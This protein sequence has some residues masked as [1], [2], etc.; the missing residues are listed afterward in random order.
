MA[1]FGSAQLA[2]A[3]ELAWVGWP[4][5]AQPGM[6]QLGWHVMPGS[7]QH[8]MARDLT[9]FSSTW[10]GLFFLSAVQLGLTWTSRSR[11]AQLYTAWLGLA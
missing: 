11:V 3:E 7:T 4:S 2:M 6:F 5:I 9:W 8:G 1:Q 10:P